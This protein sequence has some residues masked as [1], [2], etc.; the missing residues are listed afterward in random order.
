ME[1]DRDAPVI[2][3]AEGQVAAPPEVVWDV[4]T[5]FA[6]WPRWNPDVKSVELDGPVAEGTEFRW[7]SGPGTIRS[8]IERLDRPAL[9][10][11]TGKTMGIAAAHVWRFEQRDGGTFVHTEE[12]F[13]GLLPRLLRGRMRKTLDGALQSGLGHLKAE[14]ERRAAA[15]A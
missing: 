12:S 7:K 13:S 9:A 4:L 6:D 5:G 14:A 1:V 3:L 10:G 15:T 8:R 11:W 2:G